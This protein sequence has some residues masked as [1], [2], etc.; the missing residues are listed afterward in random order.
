VSDGLTGACAGT[1]KNQTRF[2]STSPF[3]GRRVPSRCPHRKILRTNRK[4]CGLVGQELESLNCCAE[5]ST[6]AGRRR[7]RAARDRYATNLGPQGSGSSSGDG[8]GSSSGDGS[9]SS[10]SSGH[11]RDLL[12]G[13][14]DALVWHF[15]ASKDPNAPVTRAAFATV[16]VLTQMNFVKAREGGR[17]FVP[18]VQRWAPEVAQSKGFRKL[19]EFVTSQTFANIFAGILVRVRV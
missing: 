2:T 3:F 11:A 16:C 17:A 19:A 18:L 10:S 4:T 7:R 1:L 5:A 15:V 9:G 12:D 14:E 13:D 6:G 8:G